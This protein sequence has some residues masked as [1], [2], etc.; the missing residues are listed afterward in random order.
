MSLKRFLFNGECTLSNIL[1]ETTDIN[2]CGTIV[3]ISNIIPLQGCDNIVAT[4]IM[5]QSVIIGKSTV[6]GTKGIFFPPETRLDAM[7][8]S[9]NNL[10]RDST[11]NHNP[12]CKG[13]FELNGRIR[14]VTLRGYKSAGLFLPLDSLGYVL[15]AIELNELDLGQSFNVIN[16]VKICE[17]YRIPQK[18]ATAPSNRKNGKIGRSSRIVENQFRFHYDTQAFY[19]NAHKLSPEDVISISKK[20]HGTSFV[21]ANILVTPQ[22]RFLNWLSKYIPS[23]LKYDYIYSSRKCIKNEFAGGGPGYYDYDLWKDI[24]DEVKESIPEGYTIYGECVGYVKTGAE[25]QK[26]YTYGCAPGTHKNYVYRVTYTSPKG[27]VIELSWTQMQEFCSDH[28]LTPVKQLYFGRAGDL[29]PDIDRA[30]HWNETFLDRL[31][32]YT[33]FEM[34]DAMCSDNNYKVPAEG[35][36]LRKDHLHTSEAYKL[37]NFAFLKKESEDLTAGVVDL[38]SQES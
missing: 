8:L 2:Y 17:K 26:N 19:K 37:K 1:L 14:A 28:G 7:F 25:I 29:F 12:T 27:E 21:V 38:E 3:E 15:S 11:L 30:S 35:V 23:I 22:N 18:T 16:G 32:E 4:K 33:E 10:Y 9:A 6:I 34:G 31:A 24:C 13:Y 36:V 5:G 20:I